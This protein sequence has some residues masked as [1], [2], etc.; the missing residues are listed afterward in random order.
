V[1]TVGRL[2][3]AVAAVAKVTKQ[4]AATANS[5][6]K[7]KPQRNPLFVVSQFVIVKSPSGINPVSPQ[8]L[9]RAR[10]FADLEFSPHPQMR[11]IV[12]SPAVRVNREIVC[13]RVAKSGCY[14]R[15]DAAGL[16]IARGNGTM[17]SMPKS[18]S[19]LVF[20]FLAS[21]IVLL[22]TVSAQD[23]APTTQ[24]SQ[25][26]SKAAQTT[27]STAEK[28]PAPKTTTAAAALTLSTDKEKRSYA[29]GMSIGQSWAKQ[30]IP[31]DPTIAARGIEDGM[32][33]GET[34]LTADE[35]KAAL[36]ELRAEVQKTQESK[37]KV[38]GETSRKE[39]EAFLAANKTKEGV[40]TLPDGLQYKI[41]KQGTGVQ[42]TADDTVSV[43]YRGTL[44]DG[45]EFDSSYKRGEPA[46]FPVGGVI[47][48]WTEALQMMPVGSKW[49]L[50]IPADLAYGD[51]GAGQD[52]APG[53]TLIFEV[54]LL[55]I[56]E[57]KK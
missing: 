43:N 10:A 46:T 37:A 40:K 25:P 54:E 13:D 3:N 8:T 7:A 9:G 4:R 14:D 38:A 50:Y 49:E 21:G 51:R 1:V 19:A 32:A 44:L 18:F 41:L 28:T 47:K 26:A 33:G 57:K 45:K 23:A 11:D 2:A 34:L 52:I 6:R 53:S 36:S 12:L 27:G 56:G 5:H 39:G 35:M 29:L 30:Q 16:P 24:S 31:V 20:P 48:G 15:P 55:S 17:V 42:P 22:G